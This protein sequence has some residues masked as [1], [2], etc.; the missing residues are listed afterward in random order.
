MEELCQNAGT[1][2]NLRNDILNVAGQMFLEYGYRGT[3]FQK[4]AETLGIAKSTITYYFKNKYRI[5]EELI[6]DFFNMLKQYVS[7]HRS[8]NDFQ[9]HYWYHCVVYIYAYRRIM[10]TPRSMELF[11]DQLQQD[12]WQLYKID[13]VAEIYASIIRDFHR[14]YDMEDLRMRAR[15]DMGARSKL[16][17]YYRECGM[18]LDLY[19]YYHIYLQGLLCQVDETTI[20]EH[21]KS[22]F[23]FANTHQP[24]SH[25]I[26][27]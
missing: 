3:T 25:W 14:S 2:R 18:D 24:P 26:F 19:C 4:I 16:Y 22:A 5:M 9:D 6:D 8:E 17:Q 12:L 7:A 27:G 13:V 1:S 21:I 10:S 20:Q 15:I 11:Y 23:A